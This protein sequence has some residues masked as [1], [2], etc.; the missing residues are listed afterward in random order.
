MEGEFTA[1]V[2]SGDRDSAA[3]RLQAALIADGGLQ[4]ARGVRHALVYL[5]VA[6]ALPLWVVTGWPR[7]VSAGWRGLAVTAWG[8][9]AA[10]VLLARAW[11]WGWQR[12]RSHCVAR[13]GPVPVAPRRPPEKT[14]AR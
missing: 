11:E 13:L 3:E 10:A 7:S 6:L 5:T 14:D 8:A 1:L 12:R 2:A 9:G 4:R